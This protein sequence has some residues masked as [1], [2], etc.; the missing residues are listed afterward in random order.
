MA[1]LLL[2]PVR[3]G[4]AKPIAMFNLLSTHTD[5]LQS[6]DEIFNINSE[7][8]RIN[9]RNET[10]MELIEDDDNNSDIQSQHD[11]NEHQTTTTTIRENLTTNLSDNESEIELE[12]LAESDTD[13]ESNHSTQ[14]TNTHR[15]S[16][17]AGSEN[18]AL[19]SDDENSESDDGDSV[20]SDSVLGEGDEINQPE[21]MIYDDARDALAT[22]A[23]AAA[24]SSTT[25]AAATNDRLVLVSSTSNNPTGS[26]NHL[27]VPRS[28]TRTA[29]TGSIFGDSQSRRQIPPITTANHPTPSQPAQQQQQINIVSM[30]TTNSLLGRAFGILIRQIT[31]LLVRCSSTIDEQ[32]TI[33]TIQNKIE[34][35]FLPTWQWFATVMDSFES[36]LRFGMTLSNLKHNENDTTLH[37]NRFLKNLIDR[38][39]IE[40]KKK[41]TT[42]RTNTSTINGKK[43]DSFLALAIHVSFRR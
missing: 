42:N 5:I 17:T 8:S 16:A 9:Q 11:I 38:A 40:T 33:D 34:Q 36:Q 41:S 20:R 12:L 28:T 10:D 1:D 3:H 39:Q 19:F 13:N 7:Y 31:D 35:C 37:G 21:P 30:N 2:A 4:I 23:T 25:T 18:M 26:N 32:N 22:A 29:T 14:N 15:T 6:L 27:N 43:K 24:A